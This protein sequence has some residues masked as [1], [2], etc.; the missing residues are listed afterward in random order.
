[1][2]NYQWRSLNRIYSTARHTKFATMFFAVHETSFDM[3]SAPFWDTANY[4]PTF[5]DNLSIPSLKQEIQDYSWTSWPSNMG[6]IGCTETSVQNC[7]FTLRNTPEERRFHLRRGGNL[8]SSIF[9]IYLL[10]YNRTCR[11]ICN[12]SLWL[13]TWIFWQSLV[14]T[15]QCCK[16]TM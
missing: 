4:V 15:L 1:M 14:K 3:R 9:A 5:R 16:C 13:E 11:G 6:P 8:K 2:I 7:H 10:I 12:R